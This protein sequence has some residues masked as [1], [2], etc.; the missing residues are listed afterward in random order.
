MPISSSP[1]LWR[2]QDKVAKRY[3]IVHKEKGFFIGEIPRMGYLFSDHQT[4]ILSYLIPS[5][6]NIMDAKK[7]AKI[8]MTH[9]SYDQFEFHEVQSKRMDQYIPYWELISIAEKPEHYMNLIDAIPM[10]STVFH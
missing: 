8:K 7:Y 5:F 3:V 2:K 4:E 6:P 10:Q 9:L 1:F